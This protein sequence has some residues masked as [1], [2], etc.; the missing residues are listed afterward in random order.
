M[1]T[2]TSKPKSF[3]TEQHS[4]HG[5]EYKMKPETQF[6]APWYKAA[7]KL[8]GKVV[9]ISGGDSGI[10]RSVAILFAREGADVAIAYYST[11][12]D[13]E[14]TRKLVEA[15]GR[16]CLVLKGDV[17]DKHTCLEWVDRTVKEFGHL[18]VL[19]NN[20]A[21]QQYNDNFETLK[22]E[23]IV[24]TFRTNIV[25]YMFLTQAALPHLK[26]GSSIINTHSVVAYK[27]SAALI[28]YAATKGAINTFTIALAQQLGK[29][30]IRVNGV[31]PGPIWTPLQPATGWPADKLEKLGQDT[32]L[33]RAG[34]PEEV[35]PA[36]VFLAAEDGRYCT[37]VT[38]DVNGGMPVGH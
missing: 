15:E 29:R 10:G 20:A 33:G 21:T 2:D 37:G 1:A 19:V 38:I 16:R 12:K 11:D 23:Q 6:L 26:E 4:G 27:G 14:D 31:A 3:S 30:G 13:A 8:S 35:A 25:G 9:L 7:G 34:Q 22:E 5:Q 24:R 36:Y 17:G 18:D 28:D 32:W